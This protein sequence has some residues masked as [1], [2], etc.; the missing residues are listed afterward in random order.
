V[1]P[2]LLQNASRQP[3]GHL[4]QADEETGTVGIGKHHAHFGR[5]GR[6]PARL[7]LLQ[8]RRL[9]PAAPRRSAIATGLFADAPADDDIPRG[10]HLPPHLS[11]STDLRQ[12]PFSSALR[13]GKS[14][15]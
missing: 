8:R 4:S 13:E 5:L 6:D 15:A 2:A 10:F 3:G 1:R 11:G 7:Y 14:H 9:D 12:G